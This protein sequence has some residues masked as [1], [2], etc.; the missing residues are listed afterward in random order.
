MRYF[1]RFDG[2][3]AGFRDRDYLFSP[4]CEWIGWFEGDGSVWSAEDGSYMGEVFE[5][6]YIVRQRGVSFGQAARPMRP[7]RPM[8]PMRPMR[9]VRV[10]LPAGYDDALAAASAS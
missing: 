7:L 6:V 4:D 3:Y 1:F 2:K 8:R 9:L 10:P 5:D